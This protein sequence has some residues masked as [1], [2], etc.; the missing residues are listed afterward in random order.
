MKNFVKH[1]CTI[2]VSSWVLTLDLG[3]GLGLG[4]DGVAR[5]ERLFASLNGHSGLGGDLVRD[6]REISLVAPGRSVPSDVGVVGHGTFEQTV[7]QALMFPE[8]A[9]VIPLELAVWGLAFGRAG[10]LFHIKYYNL[11]Y[12][13]YTW[14]T[15][16]GVLG[17]ST[18]TCTYT[19]AHTY[20]YTSTLTYN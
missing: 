12:D 3:L 16:F 8:L 7:V 2:K 9:H 13:K 1:D 6:K 5:Q 15:G 17:A 20:T 11:L 19:G 10:S 4:L 18:C 14:Y